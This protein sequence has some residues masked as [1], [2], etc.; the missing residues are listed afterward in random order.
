MKKKRWNPLCDSG[1]KKFF[2]IM[3]ITVFFLFAGLLQLSASVY[4]QQTNLRLNAEKASVS[5][6]L[7]MIEGQSDFHFLYRSDYFSN[8]PDVTV[9][10]QDVKIEEVLNKLI[11]PYGFTYEIDDRTV[12]IK[13]AAAQSVPSDQKKEFS[14][15][16][17]DS[18]GLPLPGVSVVV[19][20]T[21]VGTITDADGKFALT[22]SG[23]VKVLVFS[24]VGMKTQEIAVAG[25]SVFNIALAEETVKIDEVVAVGYGNTKKRDITGS[26]ASISSSEMN[27]GVYSSPA[28]MLQGKVA[29]LSM[30][31]SG[32]PTESPSITLRGPS[33]LRS[34]AAME[35]FYVIDGVPG[36][37]IDAVAQDDIVNIDIMK[38]ASSTA[39]WRLPT[40]AAAGTSSASSAGSWGTTGP[41]RANRC[42][43]AHYTDAYPP[44]LSAHV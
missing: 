25:K 27:K 17:L 34:G 44:Q 9:D 16:V 13:R 33:T 37:S 28:E 14:G 2:F 6:V 18:N 7:K 20:G 30:T 41:R 8:L 19:K 36:A 42:A 10:F 4:S 24:F 1:W 11:V 43:A 31:R 35:P 40:L 39:A 32:D 26:V 29:G 12:V 15:R 5:E 22:P 21:T 3:R 23:D 38:D